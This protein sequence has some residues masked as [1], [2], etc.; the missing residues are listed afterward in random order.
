M[1][2]ASCEHLHL[3][4]CGHLQMLITIDLFPD[5]YIPKNLWQNAS[6]NRP[7]P[8]PFNIP[9]NSKW[10]T[11]STGRLIQKCFRTFYLIL[12]YSP[13][14]LRSSQFPNVDLYRY[15][16]TF[17]EERLP[18]SIAVCQIR[19]G[20]SV[21]LGVAPGPGFFGNAL[22][23]GLRRCRAPRALRSVWPGRLRRTLLPNRKCIEH[24]ETSFNTEFSC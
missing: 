1:S 6:V 18:L 12:I 10:N 19:F 22:R 4:T 3:H 21:L 20:K 5:Q 8:T 7:L 13:C 16:S 2:R 24:Q 9:Q 23:Q 14:K 11:R 15:I 17:W